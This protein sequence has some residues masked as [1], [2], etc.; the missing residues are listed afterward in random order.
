MSGS[1]PMNWSSLSTFIPSNICNFVVTLE[2]GSGACGY[3]SYC[4]P[5][6]HNQRPKCLCP[7]GYSYID[8][9]DVTK[10]CRQNFLSQSCDEALPESDLFYFKS[11]LNTDWAGRSDY[12]KLI[13][14]NE[15]SCRTA[16]LS[17]CFC[18]VAVYRN[19]ECWKKRAPFSNGRM[20]YSFCGK[21]LIKIRKDNSTLK[22]SGADLKKKDQ[23]IVIHIV[24]VLLSSS[25][26][27]NL[28]FLLV[29]FLLVFRFKY[30]KSKA[31][32]PYPVMPGMNL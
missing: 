25:V 23:L 2:Y 19:G 4:V 3:N 10:G 27:L 29:V 26:F 24:S 1:W 18:A 16:C 5:G 31:L 30:W 20:D 15:D 9:E 22:P 13:G 8:P 6:D 12:E 21:A 17:D 32:K 14:Q 28:L 11:M 7:E